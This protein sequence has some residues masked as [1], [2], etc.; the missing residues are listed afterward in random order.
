MTA[1][2]IEQVNYFLW[3]VIDCV[4]S[5]YFSRSGRL[6]LIAALFKFVLTQF[7]YHRLCISHNQRQLRIAADLW[8]LFTRVPSGQMAA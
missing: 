5:K 7:V 1:E 2:I 8:D 4:H 3:R 6:S